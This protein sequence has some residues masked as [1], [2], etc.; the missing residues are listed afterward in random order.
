MI[1]YLQSLF[2]HFEYRIV[3]FLEDLN[4]FVGEQ[5]GFR[6]SRS[7]QD[8]IYNLTSIICNRLYENKPIF[9]AFVAM[10]K[11]FA[12]V[13]SDL[14]PLKL[15]LSNID[16]KIYNAIKAIYNNTVSNVR[17]NGME[18]DWSHFTSGVCQDQRSGSW[19]SCL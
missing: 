12:C 7:C 17:V 4:W 15:L 6:R 10:K 5:N 14:L 13:D 11:T 18:T 9:A 16:G 19:N 1:L 3:N 8:H 2:K